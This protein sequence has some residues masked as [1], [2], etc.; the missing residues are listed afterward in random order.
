M[1]DKI[2]IFE[3]GQQTRGQHDRF[4]D[5]YRPRVAFQEFKG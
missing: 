4:I 5:A 2:G 3:F 1:T